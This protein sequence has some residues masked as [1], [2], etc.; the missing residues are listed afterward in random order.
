LV[1]EIFTEALYPGDPL[2][3]EVLGD[4]ETITGMAREQIAAFHAEHYRPGNMVLAAAGLLDHDAVCAGIEGRFAGGLG[5]APVSRRIPE[6]APGSLA[7][8][9]RPTEQ[10]HIVVGVPAIDRDDDRRFAVTALNHVLGGGMSSRLFQEIREKRGLAYS[11]YS[12]RAGF[13]HTGYLAVYAGTAPSRVHEVLEL[14]NGEL[15]RMAS[16]GLTA[17]ELGIAKGH[18]VGSLALGLEDSAARMSRIGRGQ[19]VHR[20]VFSLDELTERIQSVTVEEVAELAA[21]LLGQE[22]TLAVVGPFDEA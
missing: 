13:E 4:E 17:R 14:I 21:Q 5:G 18:L 9:H 3:R 16:D 1:H 7:V 15:D 19:L 20:N 2:G 6:E 8:I 10:A 22:R 11:V 12:Y